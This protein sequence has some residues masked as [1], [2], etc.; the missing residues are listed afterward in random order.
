MVFIY[1]CIMLTIF[2]RLI[3]QFSS[4]LIL[5]IVYGF[6]MVWIILTV[7]ICVVLASLLSA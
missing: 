6:M 3:A 4:G 1:S 5:I 7:L 2:P